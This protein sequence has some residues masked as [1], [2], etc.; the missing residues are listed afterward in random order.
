MKKKKEEA[1]SADFVDFQ[2]LN[3]S[4]LQQESMRKPRALIV[5]D[6]SDVAQCMKLAL[7]HFGLEADIFTDPEL[8][9]AHFSPGVYD[10]IISDIKMP[11]LS[12][13]EF[14]RKITSIDN[15]VKIILMTAF[16]LTKEDF[17]KAIPSTRVDAFIKKPIG[18]TKLRDH[19][20]VLLGDYKEGKW[21]NRYSIT[22]V[23][24]GAT[25]MFM[26]SWLQDIIPAF[27]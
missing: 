4:L 7:K 19:L 27:T 23:M 3:K 12:G 16:N 6:E 1:V 9:L 15:D 13:F 5:D 10:V 2:D 11:N 14:A 21:S 24:T 18:M 26:M 25:S 22:S 17:E 20:N 8:A